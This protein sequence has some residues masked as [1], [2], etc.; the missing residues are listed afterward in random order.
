M[1]R[2]GQQ[3]ITLFQTF[4]EQLA[5]TLRTKA[6]TDRRNFLRRAMWEKELNETLGSMSIQQTIIPLLKRLIQ[7]TT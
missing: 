1:K 4:G 3:S 2:Q 5:T 7:W 6:Q